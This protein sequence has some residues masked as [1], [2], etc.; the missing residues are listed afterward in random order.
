MTPVTSLERR[1]TNSR[2]NFSSTRRE[3]SANHLNG[4]ARNKRSIGST[5]RTVFFTASSGDEGA[6]N[7]CRCPRLSPWSFR[8]LRCSSRPATVFCA[9]IGTRASR[10]RLRRSALDPTR[11]RFNDGKIDPQGRLWLGTMA[12]DEQQSDRRT[13]PSRGAT[14]EQVLADVSI[15]NGI[16]WRGE[17]MYY[18][19]SGPFALTLSITTRNAESSISP[20]EGPSSSFQRRLALQTGWRSTSTGICGSRS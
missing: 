15:S 18:A 1:C 17:T 7:A 3:G 13:L 6:M 8:A 4:R 10:S 11:V 19:D 5:S 12:I 16:V 9:S 14:L 20:V 2:L